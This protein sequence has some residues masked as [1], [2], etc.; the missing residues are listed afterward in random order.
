MRYKI[1]IVLLALTTQ[2]VFSCNNSD[3]NRTGAGE[4]ELSGADLYAKKC[5]SCHLGSGTGMENVYPPLAQSDY[6][7]D[8]E[9][10]IEM[11]L[12]GKSGE[13]EVNGRK[14]NGVMPALSLSDEEVAE[15]LNYVYTN[16]DN[17]GSRVSIAEVNAVREKTK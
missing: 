6:L 16:M 12:K 2:L 3:E 17:S 14:Y 1:Q 8:K 10:T 13:I 11:V 4:T 9:K 5:A 15:V 7:K